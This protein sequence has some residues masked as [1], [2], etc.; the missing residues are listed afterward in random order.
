[1][2]IRTV[3]VA[4]QKAGVVTR[5]LQE[6]GV[7]LAHSNALH[8]VARMEGVEN[9]HAL[10]KQL[11]SGA[12]IAHVPGFPKVRA[13]ESRAGDL[14]ESHAAHSEERLFV[15]EVP[16]GESRF[17]SLQRLTDQD[18]NWA[19]AARTPEEAD[20]REVLLLQK[21]GYLSSVVRM[22]GEHGE[23]GILFEMEYWC[24]ESAPDVAEQNPDVRSYAET[25]AALARWHK[26]LK[27]MFNFIQVMIPERNAVTSGNAALWVFVPQGSLSLKE[28]QQLDNWLQRVGYPDFRW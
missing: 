19:C 3:E 18:G 24:R 2:C 11:S 23:T 15:K 22:N 7:T 1:M 20:Y 14:F 6:Q 27:E 21:E 26:P 28:R 9:W 4:K 25:V 10:R 12:P 16:S 13:A 17:L 5:F 8:L